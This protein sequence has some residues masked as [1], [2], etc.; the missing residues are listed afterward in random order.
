MADDDQ[1]VV[2]LR[3]RDGQRAQGLRRGKI[4]KAMKRR[5]VVDLRAAGFSVS[6]ISEQ[7]NIMAE[8]NDQPMWRTSPR[9]VDTILNNTLAELAAADESQIDK[10]RQL[11]L[12]RIDLATQQV[13]LLVR[14]GNLKAVDRLVRLEQLRARIAGT[15]SAQRVEH[16]GVIDHRVDRGEVERL[17]QAWMD[18]NTVEG[19]AVDESVPALSAGDA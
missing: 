5:K 18:G 1:T 15:E 3:P 8:Q 14:K 6:E 16:S 7:L 10:V 17:E 9:G 11:Q 13:M 4:T 12:H 2:P 19:T